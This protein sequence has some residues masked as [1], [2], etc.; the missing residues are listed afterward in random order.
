MISHHDRKSLGRLRVIPNETLLC[1]VPPQTVPE[2]SMQQGLVFPGVHPL[3]L[4]YPG[5]LF[6]GDADAEGQKVAN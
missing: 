3:S 1:F 6:S 4:A 2:L 5:M